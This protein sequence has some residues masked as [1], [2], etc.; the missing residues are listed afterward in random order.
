MQRQQA[1]ELPLILERHGLM[2]THRF[3][4]NLIRFV[5]SARCQEDLGFGQC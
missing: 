4:R 1:L 2:L 3:D 5:H